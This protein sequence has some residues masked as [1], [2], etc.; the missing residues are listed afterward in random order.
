[1]APA[2]GGHRPE[3]VDNLLPPNFVGRDRAEM[4]GGMEGE[5]YDLV[6]VMLLSFFFFFVN[7]FF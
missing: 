1:M 7:P 5:D 4:D 2:S 6:P 3:S